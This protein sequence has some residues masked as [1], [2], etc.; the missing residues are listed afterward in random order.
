MLKRW[1]L[2]STITVTISIVVAICV[3][4][5]FSATKIRL[6]DIIQNSAMNTMK[7]SLSAKERIIEDYISESESQLIS[8]SKAPCIRELLKHPDNKAMQKETQQYTA[9]YFKDLNQWEGLYLS[10]WDTCVLAHSNEKALGMRFREGEKL[11]QLQDTLTSL[12][13]IYNTGIITSPTSGSLILSM[14]YPI[15]D[16]DGKTP[17]VFVG[18]GPVADAL[19]ERLD[20]IAQIGFSNVE[21]TFL[22]LETNT[23]IISEDASQMGKEIE[24]KATLGIIKTLSALDGSKVTCESFKNSKKQECVAACKVLPERQWALLLVVPNT[25][26]FSVFTT[27]MRSI[28]II[29]FVVCF[30][31]ILISWL[32]VKFSTR[33]LTSLE[34]SIIHLK[35]LDLT[36]DKELLKYKKQKNEIGRMANAIDFVYDTFGGIIKTLGQCS[37]SINDSSAVTTEAAR[38]LISCVENNSATTEELATSLNITNMA[39]DEV[40]NKIIQLTNLIDDLQK[41]VETGNQSSKSMF[42]TA[43]NMKELAN[44]ALRTSE[45]KLKE[46]KQNIDA[47]LVDLSSLASINDMVKQILDITDQTNLLALNASIEAARAGEAG[48]GFAVVAGEIGNLASSSTQTASQIQALCSDTNINIEKVKGCFQDIL[49]FME[50]DVDTQFRSFV[51]ISEES[52]NTVNVIHTLIN[53]ISNAAAVFTQS[54]SDIQKEV[55]TVQAASADNEHGIEDIVNKIEYTNTTAESLNDVVS[56]NQSN[57]DS[58]RKIVEQFHI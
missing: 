1:K 43:K 4:S 2:S 55:N 35:D 23:Y 47:A 29:C 42:T 25:E 51:Q 24:D 44:E 19:K 6:S 20:S 27:S 3:F 57:A 5:L 26:V 30:I 11:K 50:Q 52:S 49:T 28:G 36:P 13:G 54:L 9:E 38:S 7:T 39:I 40:C 48:K 12:G 41:K 37:N 56:T 17:L 22:N 8:Y 58:I 14:Y 34:Q 45:E 32:V 21:F 31:I 10:Q 18:G 46:T 53:E 15:F 33:P 16:T